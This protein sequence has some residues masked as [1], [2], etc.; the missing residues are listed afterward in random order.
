MRESHYI[1]N[2]PHFSSKVLCSE[3]MKILD[4][5]QLNSSGTFLST[6]LHMEIQWKISIMNFFE[7]FNRKRA[8]PRKA[9]KAFTM[10]VLIQFSC[11]ICGLIVAN[12]L[13]SCSLIFL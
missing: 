7:M 6:S 1:F 4:F 11:S 13:D 2:P 5:P 3:D 8:A 12:N 9:L 10:H